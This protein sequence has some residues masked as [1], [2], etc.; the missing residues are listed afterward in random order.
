MVR[1]T[2]Q[3]IKNDTIFKNERNY[4][5]VIYTN[6]TGNANFLFETRY[7]PFFKNPFANTSEMVA[8]LA[9]VY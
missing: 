8:T 2:D 6:T 5:A 7:N 3:F 4:M 1:L 9:A